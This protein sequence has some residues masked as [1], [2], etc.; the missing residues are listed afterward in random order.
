MVVR[1]QCRVQAGEVVKRFELRQLPGL[2]SN[3]GRKLVG[4]VIETAK[5]LGERGGKLSLGGGDGGERR[6]RLT[7]FKVRVI[8]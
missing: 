7:L 5:W 4:G 2:S 8:W 3:S 6:K 1:K